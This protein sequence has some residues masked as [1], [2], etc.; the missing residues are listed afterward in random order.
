MDKS[1]KR[2]RFEKV[3]GNRVNIILK[4]LGNVEKCSNRNNYEYSEEDIR[5]MFKAIKDKL[6]QVEKEFS[7][8]IN[9]RKNAEFKFTDYESNGA[10]K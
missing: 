4:T 3:A 1:E 9:K 5:K 7:G 6:S 10:E 8:E 2:K